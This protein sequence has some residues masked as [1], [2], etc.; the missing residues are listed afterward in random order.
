[1]LFKNELCLKNKEVFKSI[2]K[3][4]PLLK[5]ISRSRSIIFKLHELV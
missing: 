2:I 3:Y 5:Q 1:M 4:S